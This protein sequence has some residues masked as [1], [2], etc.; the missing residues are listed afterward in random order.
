MATRHYALIGARLGH[1]LSKQLFD[2]QH[3]AD[4]DYRLCE[5]PSLEGLREWIEREGILGFN[6]TNPYKRAIIPQLDGLSPEAVAVGAVNCVKVRHGH[7]LGHNTDATAFRQTLEETLTHWHLGTLTQSLILGT[8]GAA[9]AV[10]RALDQMGIVHLCASRTPDRH[11]G[12]IGYGQL[13]AYLG[14]AEGPVLIVNATPVGTWP[15]V[16]ESPLDLTH[17]LQHT[18][19]HQLMLYDLIYNP[20]PTLLMRQAAE[21]GAKVVDGMA[22]LRRQAELSWEIFFVE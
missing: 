9:C 13:A 11:P 5:M 12:T 3:F 18:H 20:S 14:T 19:I 21:R 7:L 22:M 10:G 4:A 16:D 2:S 15:D 17:L 6:V 1:S 8:G